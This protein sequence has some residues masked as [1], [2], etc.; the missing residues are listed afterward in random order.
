MA[1]TETRRRINRIAEHW[2]E[3]ECQ[4]EGDLIDPYKQ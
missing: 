4:K 3:S 1:Q 2:Q